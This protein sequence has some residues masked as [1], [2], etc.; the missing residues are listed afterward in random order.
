MSAAWEG[1]CEMNDPF[2][3]WTDKD[4]EQAAAWIEGIIYAIVFIVLWIG[5]NS[6]VLNP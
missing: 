2:E 3:N 6:I 4:W 1:R 5:F